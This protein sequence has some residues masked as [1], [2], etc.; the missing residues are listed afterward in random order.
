MF[1]GHENQNESSVPENQSK[2][3]K[4]QPPALRIEIYQNALL[5]PKW[6][7][8]DW[9]GEDGELSHGQ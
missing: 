4:Y 5:L 7:R 8:D 3:N 2:I 6:P 9:G 1:E